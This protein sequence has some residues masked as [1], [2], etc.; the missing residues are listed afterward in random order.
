LKITLDITS[1]EE[2]SR[3]SRKLNDAVANTTNKAVL[4]LSV[5]YWPQGK[6]EKIARN[7]K[8]VSELVYRQLENNDLKK[9]WEDIEKLRIELKSQREFYLILEELESEEE[10]IEKELQKVELF[11]QKLESKKFIEVNKSL[12]NL[13]GKNQQVKIFKKTLDF[14]VSSIKTLQQELSSIE[15]P[16]LKELGEI[17]PSFETRFRDLFSSINKHIKELKKS[18]SGLGKEIINSNDYIQLK[19]KIDNLE[20]ELRK[21]CKKNGITLSKQELKEKRERKLELIGIK[22]DITRRKKLCQKAKI[23]HNKLSKKISILDKE[24]NRSNNKLISEFNKKFAKNKIM[25]KHYDDAVGQV[26]WIVEQFMEMFN[27]WKTKQDQ[28]IIGLERFQHD[29]LSD[30]LKGVYKEEKRPIE[31]IINKLKSSSLPAETKSDFI[32]GLFILPE[33]HSFRVRLIMV[34]QEFV[35]KGLNQIFYRDKPLDNLSFGE[36]CGTILEVILI[37]GEDPLIIDQPEE[38]VDSDFIV[39][40]LVP[41][42]KEKKEKRQIIICTR[43]PNLVVLGDSELITVLKDNNKDDITEYIFQGAIEDKQTRLDICD[44]L[45]GGDT[46]FK[47]R[48]ERYQVK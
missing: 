25:A 34:L 45:E 36:R 29:Y 2:T 5:D 6:I 38:H 39:N 37:S 15:I 17:L 24:F 21:Y 20:E 13:Y 14:Y 4:G 16:D 48:E 9:L 23:R 11:F 3:I 18:L 40:R 12:Q 26:E 33:T 35:S 22:N 32:K 10:I 1:G 46:A 7:E 41:L 27:K 47:K 44:V 19:E 42:I 31:F 30:Y 28:R 8:K 43:E